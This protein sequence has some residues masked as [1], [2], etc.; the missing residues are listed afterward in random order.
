MNRENKVVKRKMLFAE[1]L[2]H[3]DGCSSIILKLCLM[4][5]G[6]IE[7]EIFR[8]AL[9]KLQ[10]KHPQLRMRIEGNYFVFDDNVPPIPLQIVDRESDMQWREVMEADIKNPI[11]HV[12]GP[13]A[14]FIWLR[15]Q[16]RSEIMVITT[17]TIMDGVAIVALMKELITLIDDPE[18]EVETYTPM[19]SLE[20]MLPG[21]KISKWEK[22]FARCL[23]LPANLLLYLSMIGKKEKPVKYCEL[24]WLLSQEETAILKKMA[25]KHNAQPHQLPCIVMAKAFM[26]YHNP[27]KKKRKIYMSLDIRRYMPA[28]KRDMMFSYAPMLTFDVDFTKEEDDY[29]ELTRKFSSELIYKAVTN[30]KVKRAFITYPIPE[31]TLF[32]EEMHGM[33]KPLVKRNQCVDTGQDFNFINLG[34]QRYSMKNRTVAVEMMSGGNNMPWYNPNLFYLAEINGII[35]GNITINTHLISEDKCQ[36][37]RDEFL[38]IIRNILL[39]ESEISD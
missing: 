11:D 30:P 3:V 39:K 16:E 24:D 26:K 17:H 29:W 22:Y 10:R 9:S 23:V 2:M 27:E 19:L 25:K 34:L 18:K 28:I 1:R 12:N 35:G 32:T 31:G 6:H 4:V 20:E 33:V 21:V 37:I 38:D 8:S 13:M 15:S 14:R 5:R 36:K 7:E